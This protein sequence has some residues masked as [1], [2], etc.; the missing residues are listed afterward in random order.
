M[1]ALLKNCTLIEPR[2]VG[3]PLKKRRSC[4]LYIRDGK[5]SEPFSGPFDYEYDLRGCVVFPGLIDAHV[6]LRDP[7]EEH[8]EDIE[9][10]TRAAAAGGFTSVACMPNT[11]PCCDNETVV[12]YIKEK[13]QR[14]A[15]V[16]VW[17]IGAATKGRKGETLAEMGLMK[18]AGIV[19]VSDDGCL[20]SSASMLMKCMRYAADFDL[21]VLDHC[22]DPS[23]AQ[24]YMNEGL[25]SDEM[26][27][28]GIPTV[29]ED[30]I[31][32]RDILMAEYLN[33]PIHICHVSSKSGLELIRQAKARGIK[34]TAESC[35]HYMTF[36]DDDC[37]SYDS[38]FRVNP[39]LRRPED[40]E[41]VIEA[42][43]D[44]TLDMIVTDHAPHHED[45]KEC[46]FC[47]AKNGMTG[48]ETAFSLSYMKL[49]EEGGMEL[50]D[51]A[52]LFCERPNA[53]LKLGRGSFALGSPAD[54]SV[55]DLNKKWIVDRFAMQS[56]SQNSPYHGMEMHG[57]A[58]LTIVGGKVAWNALH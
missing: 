26:G 9:S 44:G 31:I 39:P 21:T 18:E 16:N 55:F 42:F 28:A 51:L 48:L 10:G 6:H 50:E 40:R 19:A 25:A 45:D 12:R 27:V 49:V 23:L 15:H 35:P 37:R 47:L 7:G 58:V 33:L 5:F 4:D 38:L 46:E 34:V 36:T 52:R 41:A 57:Q 11:E 8:K 54:I 13:A 1:N 24:G 53:L 43:R 20:V 30:M 22:E 32:A 29:C 14:V 56:K 17:P 2:A 3:A